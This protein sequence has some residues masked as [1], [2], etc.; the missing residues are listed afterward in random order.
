MTDA[1]EPEAEKILRLIWR[2][3]RGPFVSRGHY[4]EW[5]KRARKILGPKR[6]HLIEDL[7]SAHAYAWLRIFGIVPWRWS[8]QK[9]RL[10]AALERGDMPPDLVWAQGDEEERRG[11]RKKKPRSRAASRQRRR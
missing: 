7:P 11:R 5:L 4:G 9:D 8:V 6:F 1:A 3:P 2:V 10:I